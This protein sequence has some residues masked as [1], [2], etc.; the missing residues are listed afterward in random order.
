MKLVDQKPGREYFEYLFDALQIMIF[1]GEGV[2]FLSNWRDSKGARIEHAFA[3][4][5]NIPIY[6]AA[7]ELPVSS[8]RRPEK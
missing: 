5:F 4:I 7:S 2:Y 6:Y 3:E 1:Q 8:D